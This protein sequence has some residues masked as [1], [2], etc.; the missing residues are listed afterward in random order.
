MKLKEEKGEGGRMR[1]GDEG[2][3]RSLLKTHL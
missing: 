3:L 2:Q 1:M